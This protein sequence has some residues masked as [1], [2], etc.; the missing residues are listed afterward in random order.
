[1]DMQGNIVEAND[2]FCHLLGYTQEEMANLNVADWEAQWSPTEL[3]KRFKK[4]IRLDGAL[5]ETRHRRKD[6]TLIDVEVSTTGAEIGGQYYLYASSRDIT[7]RKK[8]EQELRDSERKSRMLM[9]NAA[10]AVF[11][12]DPRTE[13]WVYINDRFESLLGYSRAELLAGNIYDLVTP[14]FRDVY[15]ERFQSIAHSGGGVDSG[16]PAEQKRR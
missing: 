5:F 12:A 11:V 2:A 4:L 1:M 9:D 15:R 7:G 6:G 10:D 14:V 16:D 8:V 13:C 3:M